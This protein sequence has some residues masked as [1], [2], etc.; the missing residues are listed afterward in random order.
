MEWL[1]GAVG[2]S[3]IAGAAYIRKSLSVSG[4]AAAIVLGTTMYALGSAIWYG[5]LIAFFV[6]STLWSK[7]GKSA[8]K[9]VESGYEKSGRR[10]HGQVLANGGLGLLLCLANAAWPHPQW[11]YAF[12]GVMASV[13]AD[14]WATEIGALSR[15]PPRSI[16][17]G[18]LVAAGTSGGVS[19]LGLGASLA[20]GLFIGFAAW[21]L[22]VALPA[23]SLAV[24]SGSLA[25]SAGSE[26]AAPLRLLAW[27][28]IAGLAG[29]V[30]SLADSWIGATMQLMY[31]CDSCGRELEQPQ[32]C[33]APAVRIRGRAGWNNDAVNFASSLVGGIVAVL[34]ALTVGLA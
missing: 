9:H 5:T 4:L 24:S 25:V 27:G 12:F 26:A 22:S 6:S 32:H 7:W 31:R 8:K 1:A 10:D 33:G 30:G 18:R 13:T 15:K 20:G 3:V 17:T 21:L 14:T 11:L 2:S 28:G 29:L 23:D 16:K 34:S 19:G